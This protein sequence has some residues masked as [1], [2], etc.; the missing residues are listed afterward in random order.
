MS[1][2]EH[3]AAP[4]PSRAHQR[5]S[6]HVQIMDK[7]MSRYGIAVC[8]GRHMPGR[9]HSQHEGLLDFL[10]GGPK[11]MRGAGSRPGNG[12]LTCCRKVVVR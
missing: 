3:P 8:G 11:L 4:R 5:C 10:S 2:R 9:V 7:A 12:L 6:D 1:Q